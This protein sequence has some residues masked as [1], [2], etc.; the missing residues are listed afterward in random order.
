ME[1]STR[2]RL[3]SESV[4]HLIMPTKDPAGEVLMRCCSNC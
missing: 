1:T 3:H 2:R 4:L